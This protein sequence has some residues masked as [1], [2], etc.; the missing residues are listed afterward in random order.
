MNTPEVSPAPTSTSKDD[1]RLFFYLLFLHCLI[2][3]VLFD[4]L[5]SL[6]TYTV[7]PYGQ[8]A[9]YS[10]S[11]F[12]PLTLPRP[13]LPTRWI[14]IGCHGAMFLLVIA[15]QSPCPWWADTFFG[16][17]VVVTM[18]FLSYVIIAYVRIAIGNQIN[19][20]CSNP[21]GLFYFGVSGQLGLALGTIPTYLLV[22]VFSV[23]IA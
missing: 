23:F 15:V 3:L 18:Q 21:K 17:F 9:V 2:C 6:T 20:Q 10:M 14:T 12:T 11:L 7:L 8:I 5:P 22:D 13:I 1:T 19:E 4:F 16:A